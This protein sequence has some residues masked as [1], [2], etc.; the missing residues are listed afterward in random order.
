M[1]RLC[2]ALAVIQLQE[3]FIIADFQQFPQL[4]SS[5]LCILYRKEYDRHLIDLL[6]FDA[7][8]YEEIFGI[9]EMELDRDAFLNGSC[10]GPR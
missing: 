6:P 9:R 3:E 5:I 10:S 2:N 1:L 4:F 7:K 8:E